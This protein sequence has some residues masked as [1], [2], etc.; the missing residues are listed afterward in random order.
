MPPLLAQLRLADCDRGAVVVLG[1][2]ATGLSVA[3]AMAGDGAV[4]VGIDAELWQPGRWSRRV[5]T[6]AGLSDR[7][8]DA[9]LVDAVTAFARTIRGPCCIV[10]A[11][12]AAVLWCIEHRAR[13]APEVHVS[14]G[15]EPSLAGMLLDKAEFATRCMALDIDVPK[16]LIVGDVPAVRAAVAEVGYPCL[17]KPRYVHEWRHRLAGQKLVVLRE[18]ADLDRALELLGPDVTAFVVQ[19]RVVGPESELLVGGVWSGQG[20]G[21]VRCVFTGRKVRQLPRGHGSATYARSE[22][23]PE[24][25]RLST[26]IVEKL[27]YRGICGTEFKVD[28]RSGRLRLLEVNPRPTLW[29]DLCRLAGCEITAAHVDELLGRTPRPVHPGR[30]GAVWRYGLRDA[31]ALA[32]AGWQAA[33]VALIGDPLADGDAVLAWDD[34]HATIGAVAHTLRQGLETVLDLWKAR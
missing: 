31:V 20:D 25:Q 7:P 13:L 4:A 17:L 11:T 2:T 16:T 10:P 5:G 26:A 28:P 9:T 24:V 21:R 15:Y 14:A 32:G 29:F 19:E 34:P 6:V 23:L 3:R 1:L 12:D 18:A 30:A 27:G 8:L 33:S 22:D